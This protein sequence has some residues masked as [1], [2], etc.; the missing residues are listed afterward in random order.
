MRRPPPVYRGEPIKLFF[1][2]QIESAPPTFVLFVAHPKQ[3]GFAYER[4]LKNALRKEFPF[5]GTDIKLI[6]RKRT[7]KAD[8]AE[9]GRSAAEA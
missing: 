8:R 2:T 1:A 4:Y 7:E 5:E 9:Q 6:F 3:L